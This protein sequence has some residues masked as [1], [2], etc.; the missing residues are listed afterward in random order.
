MANYRLIEIYQNKLYFTS[1]FQYNF[2]Q[3][4]LWQV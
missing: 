1:K 3:E 2:K 4:Y